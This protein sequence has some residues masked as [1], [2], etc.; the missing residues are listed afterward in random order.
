MTT[1]GLDQNWWRL[2][3][4]RTRATLRWMQRHVVTFVI[5]CA[6][7]AGAIVV[8]LL[9]GDAARAVLAGAV[10]MGAVVPSAD[11]FGE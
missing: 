10:V 8:Y 7:L 6:V 2:P 5:A 1:R 3:Y 11:Y 4:Q 9:T